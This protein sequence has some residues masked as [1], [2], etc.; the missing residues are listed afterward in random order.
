MVVGVTGNYC[1]GKDL[2]CIIFR[3][4]GYCIVDVDVLGHEA[5]EEKKSDIIQVFGKKIVKNGSIDRKTLAGIIFQDRDEKAKLES[6]VH[7]W[8]IKRVKE[9]VKHSGN[10]VINAALL[11][12]MCLFVLCDF[13]LAIDVQQDIAVS[14]AAARDG[15][16]REKALERLRAQKPVKG[17]LHFVDKVIDNNGNPRELEEKVKEIIKNLRPE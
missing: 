13:V 6:I 9:R 10:C 11:I 2:A 5:L 8:M 15:I 16:T 3:D 12:E 14:R 7:P 17:K 1:S 4:E